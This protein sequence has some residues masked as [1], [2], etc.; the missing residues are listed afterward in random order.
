MVNRRDFSGWF[1]TGVTDW[2]RWVRLL[3][4]PAVLLASAYYAPRMTERQLLLPLLGVGAFLL[5]RRPLLA[6]IA[7][8]PVSLIA[9]FAIGTGTQTSLHPGVL[10][11]GLLVVIWLASLSHTWLQHGR[12][13]LVVSRPVWPLLALCA[14]AVIAFIA[15]TQTWLIFAPTAPLRSQVGGLAIIVLSAGAFFLMG[16]WIHEERWL[17][18]LTWAFLTVGGAYIGGRLIPGVGDILVQRFQEGSVGSL[19]WVWLVALAFGQAVFNRQLTVWR[20]GLLVGLTTA[21]LYVGWFQ[22][23]DWASGWLPPLLAVLFIVWLRSWRVGLVLTVVGIGAAL[24]Q[25]PNLLNTLRGLEDYSL[26]TRDV[27]REVLLTEA[28]PLSPII[29]LGP[30]N[31]YWYTPHFGILG[32]HVQFNSH[33]NYLDILLQTGILGL[34]CFTWFIMEIGRLGWR[35]RLKAPEGFQQAYVY[36]ALAGLVGTLAAA[37][38]GDWFLPFVYNIGFNGFRSSIVAWVFLGG[39]VTLEQMTDAH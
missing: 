6:L 19:F 8:V 11:L 20:R 38:L 34:A 16:Q 7:L 35:L 18:Y 31:Y 2:Q 1:E 3:I 25:D 28:F 30:S 12:V 36:A 17:R 22:A 32:Y 29:G 23:R 26:V 10:L 15:G 4:I 27:A 21:T 37:W 13:R 33:N 14:V 24:W 39:L 9:P 5:A